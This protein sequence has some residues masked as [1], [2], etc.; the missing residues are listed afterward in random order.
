[1]TWKAARWLVAALLIGC[2][3]HEESASFVNAPIVGGEPGGDPAVVVLQ[4]LRSG[5][6]CTGTLIAERVVLTAKHCIQEPFAEQ[7]NSPNAIVVGVGDTIRQLTHSLRVQSIRT[8]PGVYTVDS[9][10]AIGSGLIG[11][12]VAVMV[13]QNGAPGIEPIPIRRQSPAGLSRQLITAVGYGQTP[14]SWSGGVK[15]TVTGRVQ[16]VSGNLIYVGPLICQGDSGGPAIT[17]D[18]EVAGVVSFGS[19]ACGSGFG[20]YNAIHSFLDMIDE[21]LIE[22]GSCLNDGPERCDGADND[23]DGLVDEDCTPIGGGCSADDECVGTMCRETQ[24]G[25]ICTAP[26]DP[27]RP[28]LGCGEGMYCARTSG[29]DGLC[30]PLDGT[31]GDLPNGEA[32]ERDEDCASLACADPGDGVRRCVSLCRGDSGMCLADEVCVAHPGDCGACVDERQFADVRSLG[33]FCEENSD[34]RSQICYAD[35]ERS[36]CSRTCAADADCGNGFHCRID[37]DPALSRCAAGVRADIGEVCV[38]NGDCVAGAICVVRGQQRWCTR[39]CSDSAPCPEGLDCVP[40]QGT[41]VCAPARRLDGQ[42]CTSDDECAS[43]LCSPETGTCTRF[44]GPD[45]P[46]A[47]GLACQRMGDAGEPICVTAEHLSRGGGCSV[48]PHSGS[49]PWAWL[50]VLALAFVWALGRRRRA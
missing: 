26:C 46:C 36:Y 5:G 28:E 20:A 31:R 44:C 24:A 48:G 13:L 29:C 37:D 34:C 22:A 38:E 14:D 15:Y 7:P 32:C 39:Q 50:G 12:D 6:L 23:C 33:E 11:E 49:T 4:N 10:G 47:I 2:A 18:Y 25:R 35:G 42:A 40:A 30:V 3:A 41:H 17:E 43:G 16:N 27:L 45:A 21:A 8:V 1:M 19:G 9:R